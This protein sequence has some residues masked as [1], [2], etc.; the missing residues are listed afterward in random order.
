MYLCQLNFAM[1]CA[2]GA[3]GIFWQH[4]NHRN[5]LV[6][7]VYRFQ[8]YFHERLILHDLGVFLPHEDGFSK[9]KN[10]YIKS[11]YFSVCADY[12]VN[13]DETCMHGDWFYT[14]DYSIFGHEV[15]TTER[16]TPDNLTHWMI[17]Y[18]KGFT[19]KGNEKTRRSVRAYVYLFLISQV[20]AR[21]SIV[22]NSV[23]AGDAQQV[24]KSTFKALINYEYSIGINIGRYQ[25]VL[26][27]ALFFSRHR[28]IH[29]SKR[30]KLKHGKNGRIQQQNFSEQHRHENWFKQGYKQGS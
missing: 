22:G 20:Q 1:F 5:L 24:L 12:D 3:L 7:S 17:I 8:V 9:V 13:P 16:S 26:E 28:H 18:S 2:T 11:D 14:T 21:S 25:G 10:S 19:R 29:A 23:P 30:F 15:K 4:F 27:H 6:R